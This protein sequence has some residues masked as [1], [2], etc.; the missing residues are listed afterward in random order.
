MTRILLYED[1]F[2]RDPENPTGTVLRA[3]AEQQFA[4][5]NPQGVIAMASPRPGV[6][7]VT[8]ADPAAV[9]EAE[10]QTLTLGAARAEIDRSIR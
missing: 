8:C 7:V 9:R 4:A 2:V 10:R 6:L 1:D 5:D 3:S